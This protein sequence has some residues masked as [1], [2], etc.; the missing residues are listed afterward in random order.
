M[1]QENVEICRGVAGLLG[2][3][4]PTASVPAALEYCDPEIVFDSAIVSGAEGGTYRGHEG[5]R[6]W[7]AASEAA[8]EELRVTPEEFR[9]LGDRVLMLGRVVVRGRGSGVPVESQVAFLTTVRGGRI[10]HAKGF[11]D[12]DQALEAAGLPK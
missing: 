6:A 10:V 11:L 1:S 12:W 4:S 3:D 8:F 2:G 7:A 9:D 5:L